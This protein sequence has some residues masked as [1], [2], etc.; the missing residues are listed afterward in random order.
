MCWGTLHPCPV[1]VLVE[2]AARAGLD[3]V[4]VAPHQYVDLR[5]RGWSAVA[6]RKLLRD[7]GV[8]VTVVDP[9]VRSLPGTPQT[10]EIEPDLAPFLA[11]EDV[12]FAVADELEAETLNL[13]HLRGRPVAEPALVEAVGRVS[14]RAARDGRRVSLEFFPESAVPD[15]A[16]ARRIIT[17][18]RASNAGV[19]FDVLHFCRGGGTA[20]ALENEDLIALAGMQLSDRIDSP[21]GAKYVPMSGRALPGRGTLPVVEVLARVLRGRPDLAVGI[22]VFDQAVHRLSAVEVACRAVAATC[23]VLEAAG[24][25]PAVLR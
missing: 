19:M 3:A 23:E 12:C 7:V 15:L 1:E 25:P 22:E 16:S 24:A 4:T 6:F 9:L 2:A 21:P 18:T 5:E 11:E 20:S 10:H 8:R 14:E 17:A 13:A